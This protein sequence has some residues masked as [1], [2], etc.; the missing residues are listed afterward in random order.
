MNI[1]LGAAKGLEYLHNKANTPVIYRDLK[2]S[3]ILLDKDQY[4]SILSDFGLAKP[5]P[6]G[7]KIHVSSKKTSRFAELAD[8]LLRGDFPVRGLN[9]AVA[10]AVAAM[11]LQEDA[12]VWHLMS[13]V[14]SAL[15]FLGLDANGTPISLSSRPCYQ[16]EENEDVERQR[17]VEEAI[18]WGASTRQVVPQNGTPS[19]L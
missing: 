16:N 11:C 15:S 6:V 17:A 12:N 18:E 2:T 4:N 13:D 3:N 10:V 14:V 7:D 9:Q 8:P 19:L 5:R 1:A